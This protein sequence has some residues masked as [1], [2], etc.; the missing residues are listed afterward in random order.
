MDAAARWNQVRA[1]FEGALGQPVDERDAWLDAQAVDASVRAEASA[2]LAQAT[3]GAADLPEP[4]WAAALAAPKQ[5][6]AWA[7]VERIGAG[8][9]GEV[10]R[11]R[12]A[13]GRYEADAAVKLLRAGLDGTAFAQRFALEQRV[14]AQMQHPHIARLLDAGLGPRG[15]PYLV[16]EFVPGRPIDEALRGGTEREVIECFLQLTDAVSHAHRKLV[17]HR[18]IKPG[19]VMVDAEGQVKLLDFGIA[20]A[21]D[22][23]GPGSANEAT[24][25]EQRPFTPAYA[26]PE[27]VLGEP[28]TTATDT[29]ALGVLLYRLLTGQAP[30]GRDAATPAALGRAILDEAPQPPDLAPDLATILLKALAKPVDERYASVDAFAADLRRYLGGYPVSARRPTRVERAVKFIRRN[31]LASGLVV[32]STVSVLGG[33]GAALWQARKAEQ[34]LASVKQITRDAVFHFGDAVTYVPGGMAIKADL[35]QQMVGTLDRLS[36]VGSDDAE[37][38]A[39]AAMAY[40]KLA[41]IEFNDTSASLSRREQGAAHAARALALGASV[42]E[43]RLG[44]AEFMIWYVRAVESSARSERAQGRAAAGLALLQPVLP[45]LDRAVAALKHPGVGEDRRSLQLEHARA[46]H[47]RSQFLFKP[48]GV[49]VDRP[50]DALGDLAQARRELLALEAEAHHAELVYVL[51]SVDGAEALVRAERG[52][53]PDAVRLGREALQRREAVV[54]ELPQDVEYRDALVTEA[55]NLGKILLRLPDR[56]GAAEALQATTRGW[57]MN[58]VLLREHAQDAHSNWAARLPVLA[59]H[60]ARALLANGQSV[61]ALAVIR[62]GLAAEPAAAVREALEALLREAT[63]AA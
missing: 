27:Q 6:G 55:I 51:G 45:L 48:G 23:T 62:R 22:P 41:D 53:L 58:L 21:L 52:E 28:V 47:L 4:V 60:H 9:M 16:M 56:H 40:A 7:L 29:Y 46:L 17:V 14:L 49:H 59:V 10:W 1:L 3:T 24:V 13:D 31:P 12:R 25:F 50:Q 5:L 63:A 61:S 38:R 15:R 39:G 30:Y 11:A 34:R 20:K 2:L 42:V 8:G 32:L 33:T 18:D 44:D 26:S 54:R 19:N 43:E 35:L 57:E 37:L 36:E